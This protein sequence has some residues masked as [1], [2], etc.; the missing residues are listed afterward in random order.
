MVVND[1]VLLPTP[2]VIID[3]ESDPDATVVDLSFGDRLGA[4]LDTVRAFEFFLNIMIV[5]SEFL[6]IRRGTCLLDFF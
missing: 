5:L 2:I 6:S 3:Q 1:D 4:L